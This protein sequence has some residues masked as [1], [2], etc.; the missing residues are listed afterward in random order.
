MI[1]SETIHAT[2]LSSTVIRV[3]GAA[4]AASA[5]FTLLLVEADGNRRLLGHFDG[6][7]PPPIGSRVVSNGRTQG[8]LLFTLA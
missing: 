5:P 1:D 6:P 2:V 4:H 8:T 7:Q 3:P